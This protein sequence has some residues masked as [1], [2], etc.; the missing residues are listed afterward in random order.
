MTTLVF[1]VVE[2]F[3]PIALALGEFILKM[4]GRNL[5]HH[6][7]LYFSQCSYLIGQHITAAY[8]QKQTRLDMFTMLMFK[9]RIMMTTSFSAL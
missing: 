6:A 1:Y 2:Q 4:E 5:M 7:Q 3:V 8:T 9:V